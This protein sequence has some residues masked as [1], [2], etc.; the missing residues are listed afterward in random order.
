MEENTNGIR[1]VPFS[2]EAEQSVLGC[3]LI[4]DNKV[5]GCV[6]CGAIYVED[7]FA[8]AKET[9]EC[10]SCHSKLNEVMLKEF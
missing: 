4:D 8:F 1:A 7:D 3:N 10:P 5:K 6:F 2:L 9:G